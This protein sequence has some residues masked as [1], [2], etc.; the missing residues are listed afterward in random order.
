VEISEIRSYITSLFGGA[1]LA[2]DILPFV[3][4][5]GLAQLAWHIYVK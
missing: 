5:F 3:H 1:L 4:T 2:L